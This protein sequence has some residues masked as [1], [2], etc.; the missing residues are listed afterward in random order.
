MTDHGSHI[1][2]DVVGSNLVRTATPLRPAEIDGRNSLVCEIL[3]QR[4]LGGAAVAFSVSSSPREWKAR[5]LV[6]GTCRRRHVQLKSQT[7][8]KR[9]RRTVLSRRMQVPHG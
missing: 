6:S 8:Q 5:A 9:G 4:G 7:D 3:V 2:S 1:A